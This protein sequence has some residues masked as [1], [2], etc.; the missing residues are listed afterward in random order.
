MLA[1]PAQNQAQV[2]HRKDLKDAQQP[3]RGGSFKDD[4]PGLHRHDQKRCDAERAHSQHDR[5]CRQRDPKPVPCQS[6]TQSVDSRVVL[7]PVNHDR[8]SRQ[9]RRK[10]LHD[11]AGYRNG[12]IR[13]A[14][15]SK[16]DR[17]RKEEGTREQL[18]PIGPASFRMIQNKMTILEE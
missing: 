14:V 10:D 18:H 16:T 15:Q 4:A 5:D 13:T 8:D 1:F 17:E 11:R 6:R 12:S 7:D 9:G 3:N 2:Y